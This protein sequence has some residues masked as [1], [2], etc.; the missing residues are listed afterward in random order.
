MRPADPALAPRRPAQP[1]AGGRVATD[2]V[3]RAAC[4]EQNARMPALPPPATASGPGHAGPGARGFTLLEL[5]AALLILGV[6]I[7]VAL[8]SYLDSVRKGRRS[9]AFAALADVQQRQERHR[10]NQP[11][12]AASLTDPRTAVPPGLEMAGTLTGNGLYELSLA[13]VSATGYVVA[14]FGVA[15]AAQ[16]SDAACRTLA[17]QHVGGNVRYGGG[18]T[19]AAIDW[20]VINPDPNRCWQR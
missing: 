14:A 20:T 17:V 7:A 5:L 9:E 19:L 11:T 1:T 6:V 18:A 12:Y 4:A 16:E 15:G 13:N 3:E 10:S 2:G 8:P